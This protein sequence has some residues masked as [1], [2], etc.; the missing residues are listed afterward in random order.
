M[1]VWPQKQFLFL[2]TADYESVWNGSLFGEFSRCQ[3]TYW[4]CGEKR[5][6]EF[7]ASS[8]QSGE[9]RRHQGFPLFSWLKAQRTHHPLSH[10]SAM[11]NCR[12]WNST[13]SCLSYSFY[14]VVILPREDKSLICYSSLLLRVS[15]MLLAL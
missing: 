6:Y 7:R 2:L 13:P 5:R 12:H 14:A 1:S 10:P 4:P 15:A 9:G 3:R 11:R 8:M